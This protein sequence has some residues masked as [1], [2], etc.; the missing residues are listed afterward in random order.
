[1]VVI[2]FGRTYISTYDEKNNSTDYEQLSIKTT[3]G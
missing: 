3:G 2:P 1:M